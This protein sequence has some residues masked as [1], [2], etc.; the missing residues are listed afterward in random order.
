MVKRVSSK[1][2]R[3]DHVRP[4]NVKRRVNASEKAIAELG[5]VLG[6]SDAKPEARA[7]KGAKPGQS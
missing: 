5:T 2:R 3:K 1:N 7:G 6:K 4:R